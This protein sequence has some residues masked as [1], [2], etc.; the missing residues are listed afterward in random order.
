MWKNGK[1]QYE[2]IGI[3]SFGVSACDSSL[4]GIYTRVTSFLDWIH[5]TVEETL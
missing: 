2:A 1:F 5:Q 3:T 4:P